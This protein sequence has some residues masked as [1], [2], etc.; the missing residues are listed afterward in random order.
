MLGFF[1]CFSLWTVW[2]AE[3]VFRLCCS[4]GWTFSVK[5]HLCSPSPPQDTSVSPI[6][7]LLFKSLRGRRYEGEWVLWDIWVKT[8][9]VL[10]LLLQLHLPLNYIEIRLRFP[11]FSFFSTSL[12]FSS[13]GD[14]EWELHLLSWLVGSWLPGLWDDPGTVALPQ[15][16][17][18]SEAGGGGQAGAWG[19]GG[20]LRQVLWGGERHLQ[21][22]E[23]VFQHCFSLL[24]SPLEMC[25]SRKQLK[26]DCMPKTSLVLKVVLTKTCVS[27]L[28]N[29]L[30]FN[31]TLVLEGLLM[32][33]FIVFFPNLHRF[34]KCSF[35]WGQR[36]FILYSILKFS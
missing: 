5:S 15:A 8:V 1:C 19:P 35:L 4:K 6:W 3:E 24:Q 25:W 36:C 11:P 21:T 18:A 30:L 26:N 2:T 31:P 32:D 22:G 9:S 13:G 14:P 34:F 27:I 33:S 17:G 29:C 20:V 28:L 12:R 23:Q 10:H 7:G 16:Q